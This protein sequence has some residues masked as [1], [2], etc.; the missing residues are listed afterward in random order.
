MKKILK[1]L[2]FWLL[3][4]R[5]HYFERLNLG[6]SKNKIIEFEETLGISLPSDFLEWYHW[7]D[8]Q[9][10]FEEFDERHQF[11]TL[12]EI[13]FEW[14]EMNEDLYDESDDPPWWDPKWIPFMSG[15]SGNHLCLDMKGSFGGK[16]GQ[17]I[18]FIHDHPR[19]PIIAPDLYS[20]IGCLVK[21]FEEGMWSYEGE[22]AIDGWRCFGPI[23]EVKWECFMKE[24][25]PGYPKVG[26]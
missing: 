21:G 23:D 22:P 25:I 7:R 2:E 5:P 24:E 17:L 12:D 13:A 4:E 9:E 8:G 11:M 6:A 19:R 26:V 15:K 16:P 20:W 18:Y 14:E 10:D 1:R 3:K